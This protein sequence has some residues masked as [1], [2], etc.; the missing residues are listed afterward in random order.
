MSV[1]EPG[2]IITPWAESGL[3][4]TIPPAAN[5]ATGRAGFDQGFSAINM[6]AKEAGGIPPFGQDFNGIFYEVTNILRYMQAGGQ[7]TFDAAL[8]TAIG[9]YPKGAMVLGSDGVAIYTNKVDS[10]S[11]NPNSGGSGWAREDLM[12][13]EALRRSYA[14]AGYNLVDGSFEAGGTVTTTTD[15]LLY[16]ADG[17][18]YS[19]GGTLPKT[20]PAGSTTSS[21]GG[22]GVSAWTDR[23]TAP[24]AFKQSGTGAVPR[25][26]QDKMRER[27]SPEDFGAVGYATAAEALAGADYT[28]AIQKM[29]AEAATKR[30]ACHGNGRWYKVSTVSWPSGSIAHE[31]RCVVPN[32]TT[33]NAPFF[34]DGQTAEKSDIAFIDCEVDG[35]R[36]GQTNMT[37]S[38][39]DGQR[40]G[41]KLLGRTR[42]IKLIRPK[43]WNCATE[44][45]FI[46][47]GSVVPAN[48]DDILHYDTL[49]QDADLQ[50][51]GRHGF[52]I[53]SH[54]STTIRGGRF[55][56][57]GKDVVGWTPSGNYTDGGY[58]RRFPQ[59]LSGN[60]YGRGIT[61]EGFHIG[62]QFEHFTIDGADTTQNS[63]GILLYAVVFSTVRSHKNLKI[64]NS[65]LDNFG[66]TNSSDGCLTLYAIESGVGPYMGTQAFVGVTIKNNTYRGA[67]VELRGLSQWAISGICEETGHYS[68]LIT[69]PHGPASEINVSGGQVNGYVLP[70]ALTTNTGS[71]TKTAETT[72]LKFPILAGRHTIAHSITATQNGNASFNYTNVDL[73]SASWVFDRIALN[74]AYNLPNG[75]PLPS[76]I[77]IDGVSLSQATLITQGDTTT[78]AAKFL[79]EFTIK[80]IGE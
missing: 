70:F 60:L 12:L 9:G 65:V 14:E 67:P 11:S 46:W 13:R 34:I 52:S 45:V 75:T 73:P 32:A 15:V 78:D 30:M 27:V 16:E 17:K 72:T 44:G 28:V 5:P 64:V 8:A 3:K 74:A 62:E 38:G 59:N 37:T 49:I 18:A 69:G 57:N 77:G 68:V 53:S 10:N 7:P 39:G 36:V 41:F 35:N 23:S 40:A 55:K 21:S 63:N 58:G 33:D 4:N 54:V 48:A 43:A 51:N 47:S 71:W 29:A 22:I 26:A 61:H 1:F 24:N 2:K 31:L 25:T 56:N 79:S 80:G 19:W 50:W 76:Y 20:V 6:T 42:S 66:P